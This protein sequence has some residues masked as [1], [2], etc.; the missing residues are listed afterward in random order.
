MTWV[1]DFLPQVQTRRVY[2]EAEGYPVADRSLTVQP[3][4]PHDVKYR[5]GAYSHFDE[6]YPTH[7]IK[8]AASPWMFKR[9]KRISVILSGAIGLPLQSTYRAIL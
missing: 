6:I 3:G 4:E 7:R 1:L 9:S 8:R 2:G 5:V